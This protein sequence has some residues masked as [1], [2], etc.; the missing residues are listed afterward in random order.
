MIE[1]TV[2]QLGGTKED[3]I[4]LIEKGQL[5]DATA[6]LDFADFL[7]MYG[8]KLRRFSLGK[9]ERSESWLTTDGGLVV[10]ICPKHLT[11]SEF[12]NTLLH[13]LGHLVCYDKLKNDKEIDLEEFCDWVIYEVK[14]KR[15]KDLTGTGY[16]MSC[17]S[18]FVA[19]CFTDKEFDFDVVT[20]LGECNFKQ[21]KKYK[22]DR[23]KELRK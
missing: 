11:D 14:G 15:F 17:P 23:L 12:R 18:E 6:L 10:T 20:F 4:R 8:I 3:F 1:E 7:D 13:E 21:F 9:G 22:Q 2:L 5:S 19:E 16:K